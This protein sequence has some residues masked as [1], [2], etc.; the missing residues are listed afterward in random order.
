MDS[1]IY[2][3]INNSI[4]KAKNENKKVALIYLRIENINEINDKIGE[5][6]G[7]YVISEIEKILK[8]FCVKEEDWI[9]RVKGADFIIILYDIGDSKAY[10]VCK[11]IL[12]KINKEI[13]TYKGYNLSNKIK[14]IAG[15]YT[16]FDELIGAE[17]FVNKAI[18]NMYDYDIYAFSSGDK[19]E[20]YNCSDSFIFTAREKEIASLILQGLSNKEIAERLFIS[21]PTV[22]K[23]ISEI[24]RKCGSK[25]RADLIAKYRNFSK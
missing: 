14:V 16:L 11:H 4:I 12:E 18:K 3:R 6:A 7:D 22:K 23:H 5:E 1:N 21:L 2:G 19:E 24:L 17:E 15:Y 20:S 8:G 9:L 10:N 25:S 13:S